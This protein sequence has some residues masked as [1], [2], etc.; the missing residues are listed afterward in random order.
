MNELIEGIIAN[1]QTNVSDMIRDPNG[2]YPACK[3]ELGTYVFERCGRDV[4]GTMDACP[5]VPREL[6]WRFKE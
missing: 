4:R 3:N 5:A 1:H 6:R 2:S